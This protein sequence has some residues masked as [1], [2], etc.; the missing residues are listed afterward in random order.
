MGL[1]VMFLITLS[2][3]TESQALYI[4]APDEIWAKN[5]IELAVDEI[6]AAGGIDGKPL[7]VV[8]AA[9][10]EGQTQIEAAIAIANKL[11]G[12]PDVLGVIGHYGS[13]NSLPAAHIYNQQGVVNIVPDGTNP[14]LTEV[15]PWIFRMS[16]S[17]EAQGRYL[18]G[19]AKEKLGF[20]RPAVVFANGDYGKHL[21][22]TFL[23]GF[24]GIGGEICYIG[25]F[26]AGN[27]RELESIVSQLETEECENLF[28]VGAYSHL[29]R[30]LNILTAQDMEMTILAG[31]G[32]FSIA[33]IDNIDEIRSASRV[34]VSTFYNPSND[35]PQS[36]RFR[37][38]YNERFGFEPQVID[39][40]VYDSVFLLTG[41]IHRGGQSR[42]AVRAYLSNVGQAT[43]AFH[44]VTGT[45]TFF[46]EGESLR[47]VYVLAYASGTE[48]IDQQ[49]ISLPRHM[50][51]QK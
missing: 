14:L 11:A 38:L 20:Q 24:K 34:Y 1:L 51:K 3:N 15:G 42:E 10:D 6:N 13:A 19:V 26:D 30:L 7:K 5:S 47:P 36:I 18:A 46:E 22:R 28:F 25:W 12:N 27:P 16:V 44:G 31:D 8:Y 43:A 37:Q 40:L 9:G 35:D 29:A 49:F 17:D 4:G 23:E 48:E 32:C 45:M 50:E 33:D 39:A 2:C 41:A 21:G